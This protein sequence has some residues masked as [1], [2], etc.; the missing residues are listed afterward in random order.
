[1]PT[2]NKWYY[3][4]FIES[5]EKMKKVIRIRGI[6]QIFFFVLIAVISLG[7][8]LSEK[9]IVI[10][11]LTNAS[12]HAL[13]PFGGVVSI[14]QYFVS[15]T[16]VQKIHESSFVLMWIAFILAIGFGPVICGWICP[17]GSIQ[18]W[19]SKIGRKTFK[20]KF[21]NFIP[22]KFDRYLRYIRYFVLGWVIYMTAMTG[23]LTFA[24]VDPYSALFNLWSDEVAIGG[25]IILAI[26][27]IASIFVERPWCK[28]ACPYG[29][30]LGI[31]NL[32]RIFKIRRNNDTCISCKKCSK[33]CPMNIEVSEKNTVMDHQCISCLKCTSEEV[34]PIDNTVEY[35][36]PAGGLKVRMKAAV[37]GVL[38]MAVIFG[39]I[40]V[41]S[42]LNMW[43]TT[44][45]K[46][47]V[48]IQ[49]GSFAGEYDPSDI[50]GSYSLKDIENAFNVPVSVL[51]KAFG[52][53]DNENLDS[54]Q[55]KNLESI[56]EDLNS[57][58]TEIGTASVRLFVGLYTGL[59]I[60]LDD[61][62]LPKPAV[63]MLLEKGN[64]TD[65]QQAYA[66]SH[67]VDISNAGLTGENVIEESVEAKETE[68]VPE[69]DKGTPNIEVIEKP[70]AVEPEPAITPAA[71][72]EHTEE[73]RVVKGKTTFG[74]VIDWGIRIEKVE[75]IIGGKVPAPSMT[76]SDYC[77]QNDISFSTVK[78]T[79]NGLIEK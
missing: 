66:K 34:C 22:Y 30:I 59:P 7:H 11:L 49:T 57:Q 13:C 31:S 58:G 6:I 50:R 56:Y 73:E 20:N 19:F 71:E 48:T 27:L 44:S 53:S 9:G 2:K 61:S 43:S 54:F 67:A 14:Y 68:K 41:S 69:V 79:L 28:Y 60:T 72:A 76:I 24:E 45:E 74:E 65:E 38:L 63:D 1:M 15:G 37:L 77:R 40:G 62:F 23:K 42:A 3:A 51:G 10:P 17:L 35:K 47:P 18:E 29:A 46:V 5:G 33:T 8:T 78:D 16:Y 12:L 25:V 52:I 36:V 21:N 32:F 39:G 4:I 26:T 70:E 55:V 64:L 75:E